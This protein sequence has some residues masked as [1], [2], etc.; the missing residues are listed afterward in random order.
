MKSAQP[1]LSIVV[2]A[3]G[4]EK[5]IGDTLDKLAKYVKTDPVISKLRVE[6]VVVAAEAGDKTP[7]IVREK[8]KLFK[9]LT[10]LEPGPKLG[11]G[12]D[13]QYGMLRAHGK[14]VLFMDADLA[15]PL[16]NTAPLYKKFTKGAD[17]VV[18]TRN[19]R[20][21][22]KSLLRLAIANG[23]NMLFRMASGIWIED[24]QCGFKLFSEPAAKLC[25]ERM[26]IQKWGFDM[27]ILAIAKANKLTIV[28][29]RV[30]GWHD[31][32]F[33]TFEANL[34]KNSLQSLKDLAYIAKNRW[35]RAYVQ[36][37]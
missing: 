30:S 27:E 12:R 37:V 4:E 8:A 13:V 7:E 20:K 22:H 5:R 25:F 28:S 24:T 19:L 21:H 32:P 31:T 18:G 35:T 23:G 14:A 6:I 17:V 1:E 26:T 29:H 33:S 3:L 2:P 10:L 9:D 15:T 34:L 16:H 11:K 36:K